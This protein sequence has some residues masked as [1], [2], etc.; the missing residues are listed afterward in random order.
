[1]I[2]GAPD[3]V[4]TLCETPRDLN[5]EQDILFVLANGHSPTLGQ[6]EQL[7]LWFILVVFVY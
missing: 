2:I 7:I 3:L 1:M 5:R 4:N 6:I